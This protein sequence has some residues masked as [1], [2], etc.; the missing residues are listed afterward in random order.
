M[1]CIRPDTPAPHFLPPIAPRY[2]VKQHVAK[3]YEVS[4]AII[5]KNCHVDHAKKRVWIR[6]GGEYVCRPIAY[7]KV[8]IIG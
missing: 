4:R 2:K 1:N 8:D 7:A 3:S 6:K 5:P